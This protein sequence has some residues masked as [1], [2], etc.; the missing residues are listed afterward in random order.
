M[1]ELILVFPSEAFAEEIMGY[2]K[3]FMEKGETMHG[4]AGLQSAK[5]VEA[6]ITALRD[7]SDERTVPNGL[8]PSHT[9][10]GVRKS[11]NRIVGIIDIRHKLNEYLLRLGGHIG[12]SV[13]C[14]ER[15]KGYAKEMLRLALRECDKLGIPDVLVTCDK[16]NIASAR[17]IR[18][19]GGVLE[20]EI[21]EEG[22]TIQ[23][24]WIHGL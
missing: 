22:E 8:V 20:N 1:N 11:D 24:Y 5:S 9:Y 14:C 23:R 18:A 13:R 2:R 4:T 12:Y 16:E 19:N 3:E 6:W 21:T 7:N 17:T 10:L 15:R